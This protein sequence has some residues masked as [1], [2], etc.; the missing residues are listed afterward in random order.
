MRSR[1][2]R[3]RRSSGYALA[4]GSRSCVQGAFYELRQSEFLEVRLEGLA[5]SL[6]KYRSLQKEELWAMVSGSGWAGRSY[7]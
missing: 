4:P 6:F 7:W 1:R 3:L 5:F 2:L